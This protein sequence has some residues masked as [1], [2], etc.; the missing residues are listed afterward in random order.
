[1]PAAA[2]RFER[3]AK[4]VEELSDYQWASEEGRQRYQEILDDPPALPR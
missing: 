2:T 4:A 1:M 3:A